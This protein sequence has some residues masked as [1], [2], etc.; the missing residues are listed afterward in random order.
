MNLFIFG[1]EAYHD[2]YRW[3]LRDRKTFESWSRETEW[4]RLFERYKGGP[5]APPVGATAKPEAR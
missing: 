4:G 2:F 3:P 1:S 5:I